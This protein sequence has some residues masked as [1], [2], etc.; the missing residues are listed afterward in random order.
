MP[1]D[2]EELE[3][4]IAALVLGSAP[5]SDR[6]RLLA[7]LQA[8]SSCRE[9]AARLGRITSVLPLEPE[10]VE[11]PARL[12]DRVL[13]AVAAAPHA[14]APVRRRS[15]AVVPRFGIRLRSLP[16]GAAAAVLIAFV[17]GAGLGGG[18]FRG[19]PFGGT[20]PAASQSVA[21]HPLRGTGSMAGV[22]ASAITLPADRLTLVDFKNMPP[23]PAGEVYELWLIEA[24]GRA[25]P[26]GVFTP[27]AGG[28]K[29]VLLTQDLG[30]TR[31]LAVT[32][33]KGPDGSPAPT[34]QPQLSG[35]IA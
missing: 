1:I 18:I 22:Q 17:L 31:E 6:P 4:D 3:N 23:V 32:V 28:S 27:D 14:A 9:L 33:E 2:H 34:Q 24:D 25:L 7:H 13:A 5:E 30:R 12:H 8:C 19:W 35:T 20:G 21:H 16:V 10:P 15:Q 26:A 29:V 11:P